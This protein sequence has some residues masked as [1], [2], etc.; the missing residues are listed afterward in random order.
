MQAQDAEVFHDSGTA[1]LYCIK[2][3]MRDVHVILSFGDPRYDVVLHPFGE[4]GNEPTAT[5]LIERARELKEKSK[6][7]TKA[8]KEGTQQMRDLLASAHQTLAELKE[9]KKKVPFK[10]KGGDESKVEE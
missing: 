2:N 1:L 6:G 4:K 5:E 9:R 10:R 8:S 7:I 3:E